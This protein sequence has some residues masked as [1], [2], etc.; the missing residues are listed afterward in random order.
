LT[1]PDHPAEPIVYNEG[2]I[3]FGN[4]VVLAT[5]AEP[6]RLVTRPGGV[7]ALGDDVRVGEGSTIAAFGRVELGSDT[8]IGARCRLL[9]DHSAAGIRI[10]ERV[11]IEDDVMVVSGAIIG[12]DARI[13]RGSVVNGSIASGAVVKLSAADNGSAPV[14]SLNRPA[15]DGQSTA[16]SDDTP[17]MHEVRL[18]VRGILPSAS[19]AAPDAELCDWDSLTSIHLI[20]ALEER[21]GITI[22][23]GALI[24]RRTLQALTDY[25]EEQRD[26][27]SRP[28]TPTSSKRVSR[29]VAVIASRDEEQAGAWNEVA[30]GPATLLLTGRRSQGLSLEVRTLAGAFTM[31]NLFVK[32]AN[33]LPIWS[34]RHARASLLRAAGCHIAPTCTFLGAVR[35]IGGSPSN[36]SVGEGAIIGPNVTFGADG[37]IRLGRNVSISPG[38]T[39]YT[40]THDVGTSQRR[41]DTHV[42]SKR[43]I[44]EDGAWIGLNALI[45]PG[46]CVGAGAIVS[47]GAVVASDVPANTVVAGNPAAVTRTVIG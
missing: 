20:V 43:V 2:E 11:H 35:F 40:G 16:T 39:V 14:A 29:P 33:L 1:E 28:A 30:R 6:I 22:D 5:V 37:E 27:A 25:V 18:A 12:S 13:L 3:Q 4:N 21:F 42:L 17:L 41:M 44:I 32:L 8:S 36:L 46:V 15:P 47:A 38:V 24:H 10:G 19:V 31:S 9:D 23:D 7:I 26:G 45:L 34:L